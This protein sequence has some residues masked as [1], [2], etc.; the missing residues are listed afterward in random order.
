MSVVLADGRIFFAGGWTRSTSW[1]ADAAIYDPVGD[2]WETID[3]APRVF[4]STVDHRGALLPGGD[5]LIGERLRYSLA[6][7]SWSDSGAAELLD[8]CLRLE[9]GAG[10]LCVDRSTRESVRVCQ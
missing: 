4:M 1:I 8:T 5:V 9:R 3:P 2:A 10:I 7:R 6:T